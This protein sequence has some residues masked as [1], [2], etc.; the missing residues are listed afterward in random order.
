MHRISDTDPQHCPNR[1]HFVRL[2]KGVAKIF[3][4][5]F[6]RIRELEDSGA[7]VGGIAVLREAGRFIYNLVT[8]V[9]SVLE[10][11]CYF[12]HLRDLTVV[13][14]GHKRDATAF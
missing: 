11:K 9:S 3:R 5:K 13:L 10:H 2:G 8:K 14:V 6:G 12:P 7:E 1:F 4:E